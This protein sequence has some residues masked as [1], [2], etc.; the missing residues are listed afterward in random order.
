VPKTSLIAPGVL[1]FVLEIIFWNVSGHGDHKKVWLSI[2]FIAVFCMIL[3][4]LAKV[5]IE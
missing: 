5:I 4:L 3:H 2:G 1:L